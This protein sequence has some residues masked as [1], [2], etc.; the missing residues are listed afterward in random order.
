M[1]TGA[2][3]GIGRALA[4]VFAQKGH[5]VVLV[6]RREAQL[7]DVADSI[8]GTGFTRPIILPIDLLAS[9]AIGQLDGA[10]TAQGLEVQF[11][12][13]SAGVGFYGAAV[14]LAATDQ[15]SII[16]LNI[17]TVT[18]L[19]LRWTGSMARHNGGILNVASVAAFFPRPMM[20][21]YHA[22][23]AYVLSFSEA[24]H[25]ELKASGVKVS[26]LCPGPVPTEFFALA[27]MKRGLFPSYLYRSSDRVA[28]D[29][30]AGLMA[31]KTVI[32]PGFANRVLTQLPRILSRPAMRRLFRKE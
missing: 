7:V 29:G 25:D 26:V 6:A 32:I 27:G 8:A 24:L 10:L 22:S 17:R 1:V 11:L 28:Q 13:N 16:D 4:R 12:V 9:D 31:G 30:Y 14:D 5:A 19:S 20:A 23:K 15:R 18:E 2:S 3:S 21:I